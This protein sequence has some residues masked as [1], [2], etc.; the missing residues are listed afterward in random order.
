MR[1]SI[2]CHNRTSAI[3]AAPDPYSLIS[4][5]PTSP[6]TRRSGQKCRS[7]GHRRG[8]CIGDHSRSER[9]PHAGRI[10]T[11]RRPRAPCAAKGACY[12]RKFRR[13][14]ISRQVVPGVS[15][16]SGKQGKRLKCRQNHT[17][18][19]QNP[20]TLMSS[21]ANPAVLYPGW[22]FLA[23]PSRF[24][25]TSLACF[26]C[27]GAIPREDFM[28]TRRRCRSPWEFSGRARGA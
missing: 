11:L 5:T 26:T 6:K 13:S 2:D 17:S 16:Q 20:A 12:G 21:I 4:L 19:I 10:R 24:L 22:T 9:D 3:W 7:S 14:C 25:P 23:S 28:S 8:G 15:N 1:W 18:T 27:S